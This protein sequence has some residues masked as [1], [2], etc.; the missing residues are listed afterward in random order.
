MG[1]F[2][3]EEKLAG[4]FAHL[5]DI[6]LFGMTQAEHN[7]NLVKFMKAAEKKNIEGKCVFS[8]RLIVLDY[9][10]EYCQLQP[11]PGRLLPQR[12]LA[13]PHDMKSLRRIIGL[14]A[15]S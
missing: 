1:L 15:S 12:V 4:T 8:T 14:F 6:T 10:V 3:Y 9:I 7:V 11:D 13:M 2:I 5:D